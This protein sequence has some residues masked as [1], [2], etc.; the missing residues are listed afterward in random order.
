MTLTLLLTFTGLMAQTAFRQTSQVKQ[1][2][3]LTYKLNDVIVT[4]FSIQSGQ[5]VI[6]ATKL[7]EGYN[8]IATNTRSSTKLMLACA[9]GT[10]G[11]IIKG[12]VVMDRYGRITPLGNPYAGKGGDGFG[13]PDGWDHKVI[14]YTHPTYNYQVCYTRCTPTSI[15]MQLPGNF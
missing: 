6:D 7:K 14:C 5:A 9:T 11:P 10:Y 13:C 12:L 4:G 15:T 2:P 3:Y 1:E 8:H